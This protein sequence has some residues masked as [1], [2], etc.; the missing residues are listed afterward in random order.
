M[1]HPLIHAKSSVKKYGGKEEDYIHLHNWLDEP[2]GWVGN[3]LHRMFRH[4]SEGIFQ[5]EEIFFFIKNFHHA[6]AFLLQTKATFF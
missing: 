3:S 2:K 1:A 4:H 6:F 5:L